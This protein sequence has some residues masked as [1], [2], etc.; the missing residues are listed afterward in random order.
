VGLNAYVIPVSA[1]LAGD[2]VSLVIKMGGETLVRRR[3]APAEGV[4]VPGF[5]QRFVRRIMPDDP[6]E[7]EVRANRVR[8]QREKARQAVTALQD[9]ITDQMKVPASWNEEGA[10][11]FEHRL[12]RECIDP[13]RDFAKKQD[14]YFPHLTEHSFKGFFVPVTFNRPFACEEKVV[15]RKMVDI[16]SSTQLLDELNQLNRSLEVDRRFDSLRD[17]ESLSDDPVKTGWGMMEAL[18]RL[19]VLHSTPICFDGE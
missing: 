12:W 6:R 19:S 18:A 9:A 1:F 14:A 4:P 16:G 5:Q 13:L 2:F 7:L 17:G 8:Q 11:V 10:V 15:L 3:P